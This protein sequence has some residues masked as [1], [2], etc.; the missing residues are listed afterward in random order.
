M[1]RAIPT[2]VTGAAIALAA[3]AASAAERPQA[4]SAI[5]LDDAAVQ[6]LDARAI[7][8][9]NAA[10]RQMRQADDG[11]VGHDEQ[12]ETTYTHAAPS[13]A[14]RSTFALLR[15]PQIPADRID[16]ESLLL[17]YVGAQ[18]VYVDWIRLARAADGSEHY[19]VL[20]QNRR[21]TP[22][23]P[24]TCLR[25][26][27]TRLLRMLDGASP[28]LLRRTLSE[29]RRL[30]RE[31]YP[32]GG[33]PVREAI[34]GFN[35]DGG[36]GGGVDLA[37]FRTHGLFSTSS[38]SSDDEAAVTGFLPDGVASIDLTYAQRI[39]HGPHRP[40]EVYPSELTFTVPVQDDVTSF[41]VARPAQDAFPT[42]MVWRAA[43][44]SVVRVVG[45]NR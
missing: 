25:D 6:R 29:E 27:H 31:E 11:C 9:I 16:P 13:E 24:R 42:K 15:R 1:H 19:L 17:Q 4:T 38:R 33:F 20:A 18:G 41:R 32:V 28:R 14:L 26:R 36:G 44:G 45:Q 22:P 8:L 5:S 7:K 37:W 12:P 35:R 10:T 43:D 2:A 30:N 39:S 21:H 3:A 23:I 40:A 34:F